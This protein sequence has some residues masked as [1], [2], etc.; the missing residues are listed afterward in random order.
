MRMWMKMISVLPVLAACSSSAQEQIP[1]AFASC[2]AAAV[3]YKS[4]T[5]KPLAGTVAFKPHRVIK[6]GSVVTM[7]FN[8]GR[9]NV[10]ID[11]KDVIIDARCG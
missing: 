4:L 8:P 7:D 10:Y 9:L 1:P 5:G 3:Y 2:E 6:P 11:A